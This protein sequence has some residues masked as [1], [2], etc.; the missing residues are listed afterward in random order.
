MPSASSSCNPS[1]ATIAAVT[2]AKVLHATVARPSPASVLRAGVCPAGVQAGGRRGGSSALP[3]PVC[4]DAGRRGVRCPPARARGGAVP[5]YDCAA[6]PP[7]A[8][9]CSAR[10]R[11]VPAR[12]HDERARIPM[13]MLNGEH[14]TPKR[15]MSCELRFSSGAV[16]P[17]L[18]RGAVTPT[19]N[20]RLVSEGRV[21]RRT[22]SPPEPR[23]GA[24]RSSPPHSR[25]R[26][27]RAPPTFR[28]RM[29]RQN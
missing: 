27:S 13:P 6:L 2:R 26:V 23:A 4:D 12:Y 29:S 21:G 28:T 19:P 7:H 16:L 18:Q 24:G 5:A 3:H 20:G 9:A 1:I 22:Q 14:V 15:L 11:G 10:L 8:R 25:M 17:A